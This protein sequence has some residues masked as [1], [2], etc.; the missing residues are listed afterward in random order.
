MRCAARGT[1]TRVRIWGPLVAAILALA[2]V[3]CERYG[4]A[5]RRFANEYSCKEDVRVKPLGGRAYRVTGCNQR[6]TYLCSSGMCIRE[7]DQTEVAVVMQ[8]AGSSR[9]PPHLRDR[10][11]AE[12]QPD[13]SRVLRAALRSTTMSMHLQ[14]QPGKDDAITLVGLRVYSRRPIHNG[15]KLQLMVDGQLLEMGETG[16]RHATPYEELRSAM[17]YDA[18][19]TLAEGTRVL[20]RV[21]SDEFRLSESRLA[22]VRELV[23]RI[24]EELAWREQAQQQ[25][26]GP[27]SSAPPAPEQA[28][29]DLSDTANPVD[30]AVPEA[31]PTSEVL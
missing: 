21:C 19:F 29:A 6:A 25:A 14:A 1:S 2:F 9:P 13:G 7:A 30:A 23:M 31:S 28:D 22:V 24:R 8:P 11:V 20:G 10:V 26:A 16:Y 27:A 18:L 17:S 12:R 3:G 5:K 15:C 4:V